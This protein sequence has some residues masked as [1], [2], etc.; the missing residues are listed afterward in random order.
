MFDVKV[1]LII[2]FMLLLFATNSTAQSLY[3]TDKISISI[4]PDKDINSAPLKLLPSG[5]VVSTISKETSAKK[6]KLVQ[7]KTNDGITGWVEAK[8]LTNEKPTQ[9]AYL[10]LTTKYKAAQA[11]IQDYETRLLDMQEL[12]KEAKTVDWLRN[13]LNENRKKEAAYEQQIK[14]KDIT[15]AELRITIANLEDQLLRQNQSASNAEPQNQSA[16]QTSFS[17]YEEETSTG[18]YANS[19]SIRFYT[20]LVLSLAV[21][22]IIGILLG[23]VLIDYKARKKGSNSAEVY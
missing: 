9:I 19:S 11:K 4:Y 10:Q 21:T 8:Y 6:D 5:T 1:R 18:F 23:F 3:I 13:K 15:S 2:L 22:L 14:L 16:N 12:R 7:V 17:N 20:W